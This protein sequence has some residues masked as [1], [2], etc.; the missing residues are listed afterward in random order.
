M[1]ELASYSCLKEENVSDVFIET[2]V[3]K[4]PHPKTKNSNQ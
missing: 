4:T 3:A 2:N 1:L